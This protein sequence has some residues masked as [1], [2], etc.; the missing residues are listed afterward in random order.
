VVLGDPAGF[1]D[2]IVGGDSPRRSRVV[3]HDKE[4]LLKYPRLGVPYHDDSPA[5]TFD[6]HS[7]LQMFDVT[8]FY[9]VFVKVYLPK[10]ENA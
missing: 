2:D 4:R 3:P 5:Q 7:P 9:P 1:R 6:H 8:S 10:G